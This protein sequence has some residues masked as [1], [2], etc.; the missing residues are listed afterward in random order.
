MHD[1]VACQF[2]YLTIL[3]AQSGLTTTVGD[4]VVQAACFMRSQLRRT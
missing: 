1:L 3:G 2:E 4:N